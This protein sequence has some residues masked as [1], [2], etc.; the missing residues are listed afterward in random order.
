MVYGKIFFES[1][2]VW[3]LFKL[4]HEIFN[5]LNKLK[6][7][8]VTVEVLFITYLANIYNDPVQ[9]FMYTQYVR[10]YDAHI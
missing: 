10:K 9:R 3:R 6:R 7:D 4:K 5:K 1:L 2:K 8:Y